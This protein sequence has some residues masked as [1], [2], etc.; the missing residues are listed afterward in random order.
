ME[1]TLRLTD[2]EFKLISKLVYDKFGINL[3]DHKRTMIIARLHKILNTGGFASF[4]EYYDHVIR[5][6]SGHALLTLVDRISTNHTFFFREHDH[7][8]FFKEVALPEITKT[9]QQKSKAEIR[10]WCAGCASGEEP[11][12]LAMV[13]CEYFGNDFA[14]LDVGILATDISVTALEKAMEGVYP[15][16]KLT[17]VPSWYRQRY[18][19]PFKNGHLAVR[20]NLKDMILFR[21]LNL[22]RDDY[23][24][25]GRFHTIFCR[26]VMIYFDNTTRQALV[27][28]FHRYLEPGGYLIVGHSE[29]IDR[30][31]DL[32]KRVRPSVYQKT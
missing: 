4:K 21:R 27:E 31:L 1:D 17:G 6:R 16:E 24:F 23:P 26:N 8:D 32:F 13:L 30:S 22:I 18:F 19:V 20:Q 15:A 3:G 10:I 5:D 25:K 7:F 14:D 11:Y 12:T 2:E 28:R 29:S 9:L